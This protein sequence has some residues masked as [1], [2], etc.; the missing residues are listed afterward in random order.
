MSNGKSKKEEVRTMF[1]DIA[2]QYDFLNHFLSF[3]ID[4]YWRRKTIRFLKKFK[5]ENTLDIATGTG[6]LAILAAIK[7]ASKKING[8]DIS[9]AMLHVGKEKIRKKNLEE[10]ILLDY[11][12]SENIPFQDKVFDAAMVAFGVRNFGDLNKGISEIHRVLKPGSP[13][14]V[15]EFSQPENKFFN[16]LYRFYSFNILPIIGRIV[17]HNKMAYNYLPDSVS[18]FP[19]GKNFEKVM[20]DCGF[21]KTEIHPFTMGIATLYVG[22]VAD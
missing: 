9:T 15:L 22:I 18:K 14:L 16:H 5:P 8:I 20:L 3:G 7:N 12:D 2:P 21:T 19:S 6:D 17:S 1:N 13:L 10:R 11:G 4:F